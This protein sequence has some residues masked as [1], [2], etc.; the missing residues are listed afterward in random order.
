MLF[1]DAIDS[2][3]ARSR[4]LALYKGAAGPFQ[5]YMLYDA[6]ALLNVLEKMVKIHGKFINRVSFED[7]TVKAILGVIA[8]RKKKGTQRGPAWNAHEVEFSAADHGYGP[9]M[10]DIAMKFS[11]GL[12]S[13][14]DSVSPSA[15]KVWNYYLTNREDV[16]AKPLDDYDDPKTPTPQDDSPVHPGGRKNSLNYAYFAND[17]PSVAKLIKNNEVVKKTI[18]KLAKQ[19]KVSNSFIFPFEDMLQ[20]FFDR[21]YLG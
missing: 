12:I 5:T 13:D 17:S 2:S 11:G 8:V 18:S 7:K 21:R 4:G 20:Y 1:E 3:E 16:V 10:Y 15:K 14:R 19:C 9:L 6:G